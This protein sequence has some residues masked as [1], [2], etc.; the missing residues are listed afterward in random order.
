MKPRGLDKVFEL[1]TPKEV[2][3]YYDF[4]DASVMKRS[5]EEDEAQKLGL[6]KTSARKDMFHYLYNAKDPETGKPAYEPEELNAEANLLIIAGSDTTSTS[7]CSFFFYITRHPRAY[8]EVVR[9]IQDT[10]S[11]VDEIQGGTKLS[12]CQYLRAC[13]NEAMRLTPAG[14]S[15][16]IR[17]VLPGGL[18]VDGKFIPEG[19]MV[20]VAHWAVLHSEENYGDPSTYRPERWIVDPVTGVTAEDVARAQ[21]TFQPF[22]MGSGNCVGQKLAILELLI[23]IGRTLYRM[24]VRRASGAVLGQGSP[25]LGWG[26]RS[27]DQFQVKDAYITIKDGPLLQFKKRH[28]RDTPRQ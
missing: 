16:L 2:K 1:I 5:K 20:G 25:E 22:S 23:T 4:V 19:V 26:M 13:L 27:K 17:E 24:D 6:D 11:S 7:L 18:E 10:F 12:S 21:S 14:P 28:V 9:E 15:E 3:E 8:D